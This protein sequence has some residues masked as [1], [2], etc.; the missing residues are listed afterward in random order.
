M[1]KNVRS[2]DHDTLWFMELKRIAKKL[3]GNCIDIK[4]EGM[5]L[6]DGRE[7]D[8]YYLNLKK[9]KK[10]LEKWSGFPVNYTQCTQE[11]KIFFNFKDCHYF[12][13]RGIELISSFD[14]ENGHPLKFNRFC[15]VLK[16]AFNFS[17]F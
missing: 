17:V 11:K 9:V 4:G 10:A 6:S 8:T 16:T 14:K 5:N 1:D 3:F 13:Q 15:T 2:I 7:K 12:T